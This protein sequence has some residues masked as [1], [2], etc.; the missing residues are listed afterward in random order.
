MNAPAAQGQPRALLVQAAARYV[1]RILGVM[2]CSWDADAGG[3]DGDGAS[4]EQVLTP[5]LDTLT[6]F[7]HGWH[8][9]CPSYMC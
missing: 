3:G 6:A 4:R 9:T 2:G 5:F 8:G 1:S 7:R